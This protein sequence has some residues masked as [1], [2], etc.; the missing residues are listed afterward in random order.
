MKEIRLRKYLFLNEPFAFLRWLPDGLE[1]SLE[2]NIDGVTIKTCVHLDYDATSIFKIKPE[3]ISR[4]NHWIET[5]FV[6]L[7]VPV[8]DE[9]DLGLYGMSPPSELRSYIARV[10]RRHISALYGIVRNEIEQY[11]IHN[12]HVVE[13]LGDDEILLNTEVMNPDGSWTNFY[14]GTLRLKSPIHGDDYCINQERWLGFKDLIES[15]HKC[16]LSLVFFRN[17]QSHF[18]DGNLRLAIVEACIA[19]ERAIA[20]FMPQFIIEEE[21]EAYGPIMNGDSLTAKVEKLLPLL[22]DNSLVS[23]ETIL[24]CVEAVNTRNKVIHRSCVRLV[25][26]EIREALNSIN[27]ILDKLNPRLFNPIAENRK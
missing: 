7:T 15:N 1:N 12:S 24:R 8:E 14:G 6:Y 17:A 5:L 11:K 16:D 19:L 20:I 18:H 4:S 26:A 10:L 21:K 23:D 22:K 9:T 2:V 3:E 13:F 27:R 25:E